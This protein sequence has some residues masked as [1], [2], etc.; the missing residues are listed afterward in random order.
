[1]SPAPLRRVPVGAWL[2]LAFVAG[3]VLR[4]IFL[5]ADP[6]WQTPVGITWHDEGP[7]VHNARNR[8]LFGA[9]SLDSWNPV[10]LT[11]VFTGLEYL[12]F[13]LLGVG[14]WQARAVP[15][16]MGLISAALL[17]AGV[18]RLAGRRAGV[19]AAILIST[20]YIYVMWNRAALMEGTMTAFIVASWCAYALAPRRP[21]LG[22]L[23]GCGAL[24]AF[25]TKAAAAFFVAA[26]ALDALLTL[27][28][29]WRCRRRGEPRRPDEVRAA[30]WTL[31]GLAIFGALAAAIFVI[32]FWAEFRFYNWQMSVTRKPSYSVQAFLD[33]A[34]WLPIVHDFFTRQYF[35]AVVSM[36]WCLGLLARW[37]QA[38]PAERLLGVW[39]GLGLA[40]LIFHD[41]GNERRFVFFIPAM[42]AIAALV[43]SGRRPLVP[44]SAA[45]AAWPNR[46]AVLPLVLYSFYVA[47][48]ALARLPWL[49]QV[50]PGV[51]AAAVLAVGATAVVYLFWPR[52]LRWMAT[53][54]FRPAAAAAVVAILAAG[55]IMQFV[56]WARLRTYKNVEASRLVGQLLPPGTPVHGKLAN[57]L[58]LDNRIRPVFV[59]RG[60]GNYDDRRRRNDIRY[61]LTYIEPRIGYEGQVIRDVLDAHGGWRIVRRFPVAETSGGRDMA[62]LIEKPTR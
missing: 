22:L 57:G 60:F 44:E 32:P 23:A 45:R 16:V 27:A 50:R 41:V 8:V 52:V 1:V 39:I 30:W 55:D 9:W 62:A 58:A 11:P 25:F 21:M 40:E 43:L 7:W 56:Q 46:L 33:R 24:L 38:V 34:S 37:R 4:T 18:W 53:A 14:T 10:Y 12:S 42:V 15:V 51:R 29:D 59:G 54:R 20:N 36:A 26:L 19:A 2:V 35:I 3:V 48:G 31:G 13:A 61:V 5:T 17:S 6:P 47:W 28:L 49:Y